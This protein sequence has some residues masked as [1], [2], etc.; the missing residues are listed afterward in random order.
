[1]GNKKRLKKSVLRKVCSRT[2]TE[3]PQKIK[4]TANKEEGE[5]PGEKKIQQ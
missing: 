4:R 5:K 3:K 2:K 1:M